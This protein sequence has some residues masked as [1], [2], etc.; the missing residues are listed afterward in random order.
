MNNKLWNIIILFDIFM[1]GLDIT[2][3]NN[4]KLPIKEKHFIQIYIPFNNYFTKEVGG[5]A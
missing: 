1:I 3:W 4:L 2:L 5:Y